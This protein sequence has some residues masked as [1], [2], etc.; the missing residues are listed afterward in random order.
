MIIFLLL[1]IWINIFEK[2]MNVLYCDGGGIKKTILTDEISQHQQW[3]TWFILP[4]QKESRRPSKQDMT[5]CHTYLFFRT[6]KLMSLKTLTSDT[7]LGSFS[8]DMVCKHSSWGLALR[9]R[10]TFASCPRGIV[11]L[12]CDAYESQGHSHTWYSKG[13]IV[14]LRSCW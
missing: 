12:S 2:M 13:A 6:W 9:I 5:S 14:L 11:P 3:E 10:S 1:L 8:V 7:W 4:C